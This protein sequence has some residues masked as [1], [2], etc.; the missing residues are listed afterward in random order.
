VPDYRVV[1]KPS[2][3]KELDNLP[4]QRCHPKSLVE[5]L[6]FTVILS[7]LTA[8]FGAGEVEMNPR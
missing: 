8:R 1:I 2:A 5:P 3:A 7:R 4:R 6:K